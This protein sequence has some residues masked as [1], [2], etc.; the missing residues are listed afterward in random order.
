MFPQSVF[1]PNLTRLPTLPTTIRHPTEQLKIEKTLLTIKMAERNPQSNYSRGSN[2]DNPSGADGRRPEAGLRASSAP[3]REIPDTSR[4]HRELRKS[5]S[6]GSLF[7]ST[8][9]Y[10]PCVESIINSVATILHSQM[11]EV[12]LILSL[13]LRFMQV[14]ESAL[15]KVVVTN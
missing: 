1:P 3:G 13:C 11:I 10:K 7:I 5:S 4:E 2:F 8:T 6:M 9:I 12:S 14:K 15:V